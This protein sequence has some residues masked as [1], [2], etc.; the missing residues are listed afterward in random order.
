M[1]FA[2]QAAVATISSEFGELV[3]ASLV[4]AI[5]GEI[6]DGFFSALTASVRGRPIRDAIGAM[7]PLI[8][9]SVP[10]YTPIVALLAYMYVASRHGRSLSFSSLR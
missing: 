2:A 3:A 9:T 4:G 8:L 5:V 7:V 1:G 10:V 6:L